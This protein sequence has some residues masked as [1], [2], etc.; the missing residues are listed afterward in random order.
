MQATVLLDR[1][2]LLRLEQ[3][4][5]HV[6]D[7]G[8]GEPRQAREE[9][10]ARLARKA[11]DQVARDRQPRTRELREGAAGARGVVPATHGGQLG[12]RKRLDAD[13]HP[14]DARLRPSL[15]VGRRDVL[16][17]RLQR[18]LGVRAHRETPAQRREQPRDR[19]RRKQRGSSPAEVDR[20]ERR[21]GRLGLEQR[22]FR[23]EGLEIAI[24][25]GRF[26]GDD[27]RA[28]GAARRTVRQVDVQAALAQRASRSAAS[29]SPAMSGPKGNTFRK[30]PS[31]AT[32]ARSRRESSIHRTAA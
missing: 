25:A 13:G 8:V 20:V 21:S 28:V 24:A 1:L 14:V 29:A 5:R 23:L 17:I 15:Q 31:R 19:R 3:I 10:L 11:Q 26:R 6:L 2:R 32:A 27:E 9:A 12:V 16:G 7:P 30:L 18:H 22:R 4:D